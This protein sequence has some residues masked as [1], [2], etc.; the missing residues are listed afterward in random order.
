MLS[1]LENE[2]IALLLAKFFDA[3]GFKTSKSDSDSD[4]DDGEEDDE[5]GGYR[6][7]RAGD[8][9]GHAS[10]CHMMNVFKNAEMFASL[11]STTSE[12]SRPVSSSSSSSGTRK[13]VASSGIGALNKESSDDQEDSSEE[14]EED[15]ATDEVQQ[16]RVGPSMPTPAQLNAARQAG[17]VTVFSN[18]VSH[19][20]VLS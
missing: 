2:E 10:L 15:L 5:G 14:D 7:L 11:K 9:V 17:E 12:T 6:S 18:I 1:G 3:L 19:A 13:G 20:N 4:G 8:V 16:P